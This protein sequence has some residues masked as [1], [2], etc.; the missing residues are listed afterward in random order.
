MTTSLGNISVIDSGT[1]IGDPFDVMWVVARGTLGHIG[2]T[3]QQAAAMTTGPIFRHLVGRQVGIVA[4]HELRIAVALAAELDHSPAGGNSD[5]AFSR[6]FSLVKIPTARISPVTIDTGEARL[7]V[8]I[9][10]HRFG[11]R[12]VGRILLQVA[13]D[14]TYFF[15]LY[16]ASDDPH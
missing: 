12:G 4:L 6:V 10:R 9:Q 2:I 16:L 15:V 7:T 3:C 5:E 11:R 14:T 8:D 1:G 13:T